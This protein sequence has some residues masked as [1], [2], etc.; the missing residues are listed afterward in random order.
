MSDYCNPK[1]DFISPLRSVGTVVSNAMV[2]SEMVNTGYINKK[3]Y[4]GL[5]D[6]VFRDQ[7]GIVKRGEIVYQ[8]NDNRTLGCL[9]SCSSDPQYIERENCTVKGLTIL[10]GQG[11]GTLSNWD[12]VNTIQVMGIVEMS[13]D[14]NCSARF[15]VVSGGIHDVR[16]NG[17]ETIEVGDWV[18]AHAPSHEEMRNGGGKCPRADEKAGVQR[19]WYKPYRPELHRFQLKQ[20]YSCLQDLNHTKGYM[21]GFR[22]NCRDFYDSVMGMFMVIFARLLPDVRA[23][24]TGPASERIESDADLLAFLLAKA[25]HSEAKALK[26]GVYDVTRQQQIIDALFVPFSTN[27]RNATEYLFSQDNQGTTKRERSLTERLNAIQEKS[28][29]LYLE[30]MAYFMK[31]LSNLIVGQAK[32]TARPGMDFSLMLK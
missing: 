20:I 32:S 25:G 7:L 23:A 9:T 3:P 13:N 31:Q 21:P 8:L 15:N 19:L 14:Q 24:L 6:G 12:F 4:Y 22:R 1:H 27:N 16:N 11:D 17:N 30:S 2:S 29:G 26:Q 5:A 18:Y 28:T 10:N